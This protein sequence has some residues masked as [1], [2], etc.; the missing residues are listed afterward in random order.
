MNNADLSQVL[1]RTANL[2]EL[3][4]EDSFKIRAYRKA[5]EAVEAQEKDIELLPDVSEIATFSGIGK[6]MAANIQELIQSGS[7]PKLRELEAQIPKGVEEMLRI[8]GLGPSKV[9]FLWLEHKIDSIELVEKAA[10]NGRLVKLKGFGAKTIAGLLES[11]SVWRES[12]NLILLHHA[13]KTFHL[14]S[15]ALLNSLHKGIEVHP[16]GEIAQAMPVVSLIEMEAIC[17]QGWNLNT[18]PQE[19]TALLKF[20]SESCTATYLP[21]KPLDV[22]IH[23][24]DSR[25]IDPIHSLLANQSAG[26]KQVPPDGWIQLSDIEGVL[27]VHSTWSDGMDEIRTLALAC[28]ERGYTY[29]GMTDHS[30]TAAY[31]GGL[32][33]ERV[34]KQWKEIEALN[35]E[36][37]PFHI[38]RGIESDILA[39]GSLDYPN[40]VLE[41]FDFV[42]ASIHSGFQMTEIQATERLIRAAQNPAT[43]ILGHLTGR[44]LLKRKGYPVNHKAVIECCATYGTAIELN[45]NPYRMDMDWEWIDF[46]IESGVKIAINPDA[47]RISDLDYVSEGILIARK[48]RLT[49]PTTL[50]AM[51]TEKLAHW[52]RNKQA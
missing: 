36:L 11:I 5:A 23:F 16:Y 32:S 47:H 24:R 9:R 19:L 10:L 28:I 49:H 8:R 44:L 33:I 51:D 48:G 34:Q 2:M 12:K 3:L 6:S 13:L 35:A 50:N 30:R 42:I 4:T 18:L 1:E 38:F 20:E 15:K 21:A 25:N 7:F 29:L 46:A 26:P 22:R 17:K 40:D 39:D 37:A 43:S 27:H 45:C 31:A 41:G 14:V 52:F